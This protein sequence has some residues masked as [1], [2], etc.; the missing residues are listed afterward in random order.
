MSL[1]RFTDHVHSYA[2]F[3]A[4]LLNWTIIGSA[5]FLSL[6][7]NSLGRLSPPVLC[8][9]LPTCLSDEFPM[10]KLSLWKLIDF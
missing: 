6:L 2:R 10:L 8:N 1:S 7:W 5:G 9:G 3:R 4:R